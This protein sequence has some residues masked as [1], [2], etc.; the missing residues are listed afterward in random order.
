LGSFFRAI[1][2]GQLLAT[3]LAIAAG[4]WTLKT[5]AEAVLEIDYRGLCWND[6]RQEVLHRD[7]YTCTYC[8]HRGNARTLE[9]DHRT[10]VS[11][12]GGD[13]AP[14]LVTACWTC[15]AEKGSRTAW[16]YRLWRLERNLFR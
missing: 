2:W 3:S 8:G 5:L 6:L 14:N 12:G 1:D 15:N 16:E 13:D 7:D 10:P 9:I 4:V 11:R